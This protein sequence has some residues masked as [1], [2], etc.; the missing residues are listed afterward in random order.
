MMARGTDASRQAGYTT[1]SDFRH[2]LIVVL[3]D[4]REE[5]IYRWLGGFAIYE[6]GTERLFE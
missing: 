2:G 1:A 6:D 3:V 5:S 4:L